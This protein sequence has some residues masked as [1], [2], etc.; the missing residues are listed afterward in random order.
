MWPHPDLLDNTDYILAS[1]ATD[2][3]S[4]Y[5]PPPSRSEIASLIGL[6]SQ[7]SEKAHDIL[8]LHF[9]LLFGYDP[10]SSTLFTCRASTHAFVRIARVVLSIDLD[11]SPACSAIE[12]NS[13]KDRRKVSELFGKKTFGVRS[14][15]FETGV[16]PT[17]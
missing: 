5:V 12:S 4:Q 6:D 7:I 8:Y 10:S 2:R 3:E 11:S 14:V 13:L 1:P 15:C 16:S 9:V 17:P